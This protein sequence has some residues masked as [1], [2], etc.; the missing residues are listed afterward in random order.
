MNTDNEDFFNGI[1]EEITY[2]DILT[3]LALHGELTITIPVEEE[4]SV[5]SGL[6]TLKAKLNRKAMEEGER[7]EEAVLEFYSTPSKEF[8]DCLDLNIQLK[9]KGT[10]KIKAMKIADNTL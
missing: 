3:N 9:K 1:E 7:I 4:G 2:S 10:V 6:K 8:E 5:K